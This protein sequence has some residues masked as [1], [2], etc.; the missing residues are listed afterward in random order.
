MAFSSKSTNPNPLLRMVRQR[1][2]ALFGLPFLGLVVFSSFALSTF[3]QTRYD[4]NDSKTKSMSKEEE[5]GMSKDRK[6]VDI[7]EEYYVSVT[8]AETEA[9]GRGRG[10]FSERERGRELPE[11]GRVCEGAGLGL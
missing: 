3:T 11:D 1:P 2:F 4:L 5:L 10:R 6:K 8:W 9:V 7:R